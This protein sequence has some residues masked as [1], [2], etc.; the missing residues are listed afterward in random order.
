MIEKSSTKSTKVRINPFQRILEYNRDS[1]VRQ[2]MNLY[3][4]PSL[5][6]VL[7]VSRRELSISA[8]LADLF[9]EDGFHGMGSLP[10][11]L[12]LEKVL[13]RAKAQEQQDEELKKDFKIP[14]R[15]FF[16]AL[17]RSILSRTG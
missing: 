11:M 14:N 15:Y 5:F 4:T 2:L 1:L 7:D 12:L 6:D 17:E 16:P 13:E 8:F 3:E 10:L 9:R